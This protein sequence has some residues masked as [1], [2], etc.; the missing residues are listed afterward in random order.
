MVAIKYAAVSI[1]LGGELFFGSLPYHAF[2][3]YGFWILLV[4]REFIRP[5]VAG[6]AEP[7]GQSGDWYIWAWRSSH[8]AQRIP[9]VYLL[10]KTFW[11]HFESPDTALGLPDHKEPRD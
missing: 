5:I 11:K 10:R 1:F 2:Y 3:F 8:L 6:M 7:T 9:G 4:E